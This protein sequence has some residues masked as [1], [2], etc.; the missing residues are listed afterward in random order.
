MWAIRYGVTP[1]VSGCELQSF[2]AS[3]IVPFVF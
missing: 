3:E 2:M 1:A